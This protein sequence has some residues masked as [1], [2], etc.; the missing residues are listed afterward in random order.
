[1][2]VANVIKGFEKDERI[3]QDERK[4][5]DNKCIKQML[6]TRILTYER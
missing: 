4:L 5:L 3:V 2:F 6:I 1:M